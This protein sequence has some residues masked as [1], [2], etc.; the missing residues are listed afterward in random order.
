MKR[1]NIKCLAVSLLLGLS[2]LLI[3]VGSFGCSLPIIKPLP[4]PNSPPPSPPAAAPTNPQWIPPLTEEPDSPPPIV[5][6]SD[7]P[8][9][10][11]ITIV[12]QIKP[13][14]V[15]IN[16]KV[17]TF[18]IFNRPVT[19]EG[20]GSG[21]IITEDGYVV[22]NNHVIDGAE[23]ITVTLNDGQTF[24]AGVVGT[25][26][27]S[28]IAVVKINA[29]NLTKAEVGESSQL[30]IGEWVLAV[31][32]SLNLGVTPSEGIIRS[33]GVSVPISAGQTLY[34]LIGTSTPINPGNSGGPLVNMRGEVVGITTVKIAMVGVEGMGWAI[35]TETAIPV[36]ESLIQTGQVTRPWLGIL[37]FAVDEGVFIAEVVPA[38]PADDAG[39]KAED[40]IIALDDEKISTAED[41]T[42]A[43]ISREIGQSVKITFLRGDTEETT[44]ATLGERPSS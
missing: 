20:A 2:L 36:I 41:L 27:F 38:G 4:P 43:I 10:D 21:W 42:Q 16:T 5:E 28:D 33:S 24:P 11:F 13:S 17:I 18:D 9:P 1:V 23:N 34:G 44:Y 37:L 32:N 35:G 30:Q 39:L 14:V 3:T 26:P 29:A 31:G 12:S 19:K 40:I 8:L 6:E 15:A 7:S 22:T 25:D